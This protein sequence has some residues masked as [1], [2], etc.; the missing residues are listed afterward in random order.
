MVN[1][2]GRQAEP[3]FRCIVLGWLNTLG[4]CMRQGYERLCSMA[5][6]IWRS[7]HLHGAGQPLA[8]DWVDCRV[9][10]RPCIRTSV[11]ARRQQEVALSSQSAMPHFT[12]LMELSPL[13]MGNNGYKIQECVQ[14]VFCK[15]TVDAI[16]TCV[17]LQSSERDVWSTQ[18]S[19]QAG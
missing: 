1:R 8:L 2:A 9:G 4:Y 12:L 14:V 10:G 18:G 5:A 7:Q 11:E 15:N 6:G 13:R 17:C 3:L 16:S 19:W